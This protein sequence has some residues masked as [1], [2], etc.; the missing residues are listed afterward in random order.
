MSEVTPAPA[1]AAEAPGWDADLVFAA[2]GDPVR[3]RIL[4]VLA[5]GKPRTATQLKGAANRRLDATLKHLVVLRKSGL[6]VAQDN[7]A[8]GRRQLYTL[9]PMVK[10]TPTP[11]GGR[12]LDFGPCVVRA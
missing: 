10:V 9:T 4:Q 8:D 11:A 12:E 1:P 6:V 3:R 7:P 5:D 2:L